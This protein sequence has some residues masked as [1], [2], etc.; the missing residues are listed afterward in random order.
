MT[1]VDCT[2]FVFFFKFIYESWPAPCSH[3]W[4]MVTT[5]VYVEVFNFDFLA[6]F[7]TCSI[8]GDPGREQ[9][10]LSW[11]GGAC[12]LL[13]VC[14]RRSPLPPRGGG[15]R[16]YNHLENLYILHKKVCIFVDVCTIL[17]PEFPP[18]QVM[19]ILYLRSVVYLF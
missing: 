4:Y 6:N 1:A 2:R 5:A 16:G 18:M 15:P 3:F 13:G 12:Q 17:V 14:G 10:D 19:R 11:P 8:V 9:N 7:R